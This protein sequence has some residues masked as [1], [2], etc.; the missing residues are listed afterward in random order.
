MRGSRKVSG[1]TTRGSLIASHTV[2]STPTLMPKT[3]SLEHRV[4][5]LG[6]CEISA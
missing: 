1:G 5:L 4:Q 2:N 3:F 6:F